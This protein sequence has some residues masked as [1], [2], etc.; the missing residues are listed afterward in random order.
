MIPLLEDF[1]FLRPWWLLALPLGAAAAAVLRSRSTASWHQVCEPALLSHL[2]VGERKAANRLS[3]LLLAVGWAAATI[4][5]AGPA[6]EREDAPI[7]AKSH[8]VIVVLSVSVTMDSNDVLP[9]RLE[10]ARYAAISLIESNPQ[11][12]A[13]LV[14]F[15]G[16][17][18]DAAPVSEDN[19]TIIHLLRSLDTRVVPMQGVAASD[20]LR[21]A[22]ALLA[23]SGYGSG[24]VVLFAD[25]IDQAALEVANMLSTAGYPV[26]VMA[27]GTEQGAPIPASDG[28]FLVDADRNI[29]LAPVDMAALE[30]LATA[31]DGFFRSLADSDTSLRL[32]VSQ[33]AAGEAG[34]FSDRLTTEKWKD[35]GAWLLL[36]VVP[37]AALVFRRGWLFAVCLFLILP[38]QDSVAFEWADLWKRAD[39]RTADAFAHGDFET[40]AK[41]APDGAW[42]GAALYRNGLYVSAAKEFAKQGGAVDIYNRGNA[43]AKSGALLRAL[44]QYEKAIEI[45]PEFEDAHFN[46]ELILKALRNDRGFQDSGQSSQ[47]EST[48]RVGAASQADDP[49]RQSGDQGESS[50]APQSGESELQARDDSSQ[51]QIGQ[52]AGDDQDQRAEHANSVTELEIADEEFAQVMDQWLRKI[53]DDPS[54]L[55]RRKFIYQSEVRGN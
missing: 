6:W 28:G 2:L 44:Q 22:G 37:L 19:R 53:P 30:N 47:N 40:A 15:A 33:V 16:E 5:L 10:R 38:A 46:R 27:V 24:E 13:G 52:M 48:G 36:L 43:L 49:E 26:S 12:A 20:G 32:A 50:S 17:A 7:F 4:A 21:R 1:V 9:S 41:I 29:I 34:A 39:Q 55:L 3:R 45:D 11:I 23:G 42:R 25:G 8:A 35:Q 18:F 31:G 54:G 51:G 14:V